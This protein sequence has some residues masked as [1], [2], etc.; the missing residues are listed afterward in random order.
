MVSLEALFLAMHLVPLNTFKE[1]KRLGSTTGNYIFKVRF[2][3][4]KSSNLTA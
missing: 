2:S 3:N 1:K 4:L